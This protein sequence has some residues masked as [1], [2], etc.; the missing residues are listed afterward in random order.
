MIMLALMQILPRDLPGI[1][2][3]PGYGAAHRAPCPVRL[4]AQPGRRPGERH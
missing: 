1:R 2:M 3:I 4:P